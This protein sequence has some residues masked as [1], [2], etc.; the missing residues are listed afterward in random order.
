M[1]FTDF[2]LIVPYLII[3]YY[4]FFGQLTVGVSQSLK[5]R[6]KYPLT[7]QTYYESSVS[8]TALVAFIK[9]MGW[10]KVAMA[11]GRVESM[12]VIPH[13]NLSRRH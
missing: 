8:T 12:Q 11:I 6:E 13:Q 1:S 9:S 4:I 2:R 3:P 7:V 10:K 5:D